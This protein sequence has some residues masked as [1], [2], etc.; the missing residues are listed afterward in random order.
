MVRCDRC[1]SGIDTGSDYIQLCH[2][3][4]HMEFESRFCSAD[5]AVSYLEDGLIDTV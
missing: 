1:G 5:C 3:H 2:H 4:T